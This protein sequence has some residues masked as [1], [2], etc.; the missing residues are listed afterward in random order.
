MGP[1]ADCF[2]DSIEATVALSINEWQ[3]KREVQCELRQFQP[4][5]PGK[6]FVDLHAPRADQ[7]DLQCLR[8][9][10]REPAESG[11]GEGGNKIS[12]SELEQV[13]APLVSE[14]I[15]GTLICVHDL[16]VLRQLNI[17]LAV[18]KA[19]VDYA[20]GHVGDLRG[21]NTVVLAPDW[22]EKLPRFEHILM[23]DGFINE[24]ERRMAQKRCEEATSIEVTG[25]EKH[26]A[27]T[28][29]RL[30]PDDDELR[31][32]YRVLRRREGSQ[33]TAAAVSAEADVTIGKLWCAVYI[34][35]E[36]GL[37]TLEKNGFRY[38]LI[39]DKKVSLSDSV[40]RKRI[41]D[42]TTQGVIG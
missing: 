24:T 30:L 39:P 14:R 13:L 4:F 32:I 6:A 20:V 31:G 12:F 8:F 33:T 27:N 28:A 25:L 38:S 15:Q 34:F 19:K 2:P 11:S 29:K 16:S 10:V 35:K 17:R 37:I 23:A 5:M 42:L 7:L 1:S 3:G 22:E 21:F 40:L 41:Q 36:L 26:H 9:L 18:M